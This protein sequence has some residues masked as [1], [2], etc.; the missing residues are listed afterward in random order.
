MYNDYFGFKYDPFAPV[1]SGRTLFL[2]QHHREALAHLLYGIQYGGSFVLLTGPHGVGKTA[3][4]DT[5][6]AQLPDAYDCAYLH[7]P[8]YEVFDLVN[9]ICLALQVPPATTVRRSIKERIDAL[10]RHLLNRFGC[11]RRVVLLIDNAQHYSSELLEQLRLLTN[12]ET[13]QHKLLNIVL[14]GD[15][16]LTTRLRQP[17]LRQLTQRITSR[18]QLTPLSL[19][20]TGNYIRHRLVSAGGKAA[21]FNNSAIAA[22]WRDTH[23]VPL[24]INQ[25]C[26]RT[27]HAAYALEQSQVTTALIHAEA[28][29]IRSSLNSPYKKSWLS[30]A[31]V[32]AV[33]S[34]A[35]LG[36]Y[37]VSRVTADNPIEPKAAMAAAD[38]SPS[39]ATHPPNRNNIEIL[40]LSEWQTTLPS[41]A[42]TTPAGNGLESS[43]LSQAGAPVVYCDFNAP[44]SP[45]NNCDTPLAGIAA[46]GEE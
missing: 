17:G 43:S 45:T 40:Q 20:E 2:S 4:L 37:V 24:L 11:G 35:L 15:H 30:L 23:G 32:A 42:N 25:L 9:A 10:N 22:V 14:A 34:L 36:S 38:S 3:I 33:G 44:V 12:L 27:L 18:Y 41:R 29:T 8:T 1:I 16:G 19:E 13:S 31:A 26:D 39:T 21:L 28:M 6:C 46:G 5:L 7:Q